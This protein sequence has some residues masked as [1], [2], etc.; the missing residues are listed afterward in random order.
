MASYADP[1]DMVKRYD[2]RHLGDLVSDSGSRIGKAEVLSHPNLQAALD[3]AA[4]MIESALFQAQRYTQDDLDKLTGNSRQLL[5]RL[6]C[7]LAI[8]LLWQRRPWSDDDRREDAIE[9]ATK[10]LEDLRRGVTVLNVEA[11]K[12]AGLPAIRTPTI[13]RI[14]R[15]NL[16]VDRASA[17][18]YPTRLLPGQISN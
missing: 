15:L 12:Q 7:V 18:Y 14:N 11:A 8:S 3:D 10:Q 16:V 4:G 6:N 9:K 2:E 17:G 1:Y 13:S 5:V